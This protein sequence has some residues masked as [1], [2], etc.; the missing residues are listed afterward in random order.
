MGRAADVK[1]LSVKPPCTG[2]PPCPGRRAIS[3]DQD[4]GQGQFAVVG[5]L[6]WRQPKHLAPS[7]GQGPVQ[8][9]LGGLAPQKLQSGSSSISNEGAQQ[10]ALR[11]IEH[12]HGVLLSVW[13]VIKRRYVRCILG[14]PAVQLLLNVFF[15]M[16]QRYGFFRNRLTRGQQRSE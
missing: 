9:V 10:T 1:G 15:K 7:H 12:A 2:L 3:V 13:S 14:H 8:I 6:S 5:D 16:S 11:A 4:M